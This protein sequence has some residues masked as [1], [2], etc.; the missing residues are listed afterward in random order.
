M[1]S[2]VFPCF[3]SGLIEINELVRLEFF[4]YFSWIFISSPVCLSR[5]CLILKFEFSM[6]KFLKVFMWRTPNFPQKNMWNFIYSTLS[7]LVLI[8]FLIYNL[9][10][11]LFLLNAFSYW[12]FRSITDY[13]KMVRKLM[14]ENS[15]HII[16]EIKLKTK[17]GEARDLERPIQIFPSF[18]IQIIGI[19]MGLKNFLLLLKKENG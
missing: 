9:K 5:T 3:A 12:F 16:Q 11:F 13:S 8:L 17:W 14:T 10:L 18:H 2:W 4:I 19:K 15:R 1:N 7:S 6:S